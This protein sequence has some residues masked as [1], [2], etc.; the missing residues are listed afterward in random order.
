VNVASIS[1]LIANRDIGGRGYEASKA[2]LAAFTRAV[3]ADWAPFGVGVT[4]PN[5]RWFA[6]NP[7]LERTILGMVPLGRL[8]QPHE[9]APL[10]LYLASDASSYMTGAVVVIDGGY[11][12][13]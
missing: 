1:G 2:A 3:A 6:E 5:R 4:E 11:T 9:I 10:A 13:W 12:I 8:G 7:E